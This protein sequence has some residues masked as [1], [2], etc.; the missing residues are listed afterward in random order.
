MVYKLNNL[1]IAKKEPF[2]Q[3][4]ECNWLIKIVNICSLHLVRPYLTF[5]VDVARRQTS[6]AKTTRW[7]HCASPIS[8]RLKKSP[9]SFGQLQE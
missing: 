3:Y 7:A 2:W 5:G 6:S 8:Q 4:C 1:I 9:G